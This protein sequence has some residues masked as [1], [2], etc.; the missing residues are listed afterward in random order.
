MQILNFF[1]YLVWCV[2]NCISTVTG[3]T[4]DGFTFKDGIIGVITII[5]CFVLLYLVCLFIYLLN[6]KHNK[7]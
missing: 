4:S 2:F 7:K 1:K 6:K 5:V 3:H